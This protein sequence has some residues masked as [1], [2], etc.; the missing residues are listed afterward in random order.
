[1]ASLSRFEVT[2]QCLR[3]LRRDYLQF[4]NKIMDV[5]Y[6]NKKIILKDHSAFFN[7]II[8]NYIKYLKALPKA[9]NSFSPFELLLDELIKNLHESNYYTT[10]EFS[11]KNGMEIKSESEKAIKK[12]QAELLKRMDDNYRPPR[13][14]GWDNYI[15]SAILD[16]Y[17]KLP[18]IEREKISCWEIYTQISGLRLENNKETR[19]YEVKYKTADNKVTTYN[20]KPYILGIDESSLSF[21]LVGLSKKPDEDEQKSSPFTL[22]LL[23]IIDLEDTGVS[24]HFEKDERNRLRELISRYGYAYIRSD[25]IKEEEEIIQVKLTK[26]GYNMFLNVI[27][28]QRPLPTAVEEHEKYHILKFD[29]SEKQIENYFH[30]FGK[31]AEIIKPQKLRSKFAKFY[32]NATKLYEQDY[33]NEKAM[34]GD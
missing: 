6:E 4:E 28:R 18:T 11:S 32:K 15:I 5:V 13:Y 10:K 20:F 8:V 7:K 16:R 24:F 22:K 33:I 19:I 26:K 14:N 25:L 34:D 3:Q 29:C 21:Y 17:T 30:N 27:T 12:I 2:P 23:R 1:M 31:E 9:E